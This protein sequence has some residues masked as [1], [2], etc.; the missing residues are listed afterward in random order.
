[1]PHIDDDF[2]DL[3][4]ELARQIKQEID[5]MKE[6]T[7]STIV[8]IEEE[9]KRKIA[10]DISSLE[11]RIIQN[12]EFELNKKI[13][14]RINEINQN[15]LLA[16]T[17]YIEKFISELKAKIASLVSKYPE[18][19]FRFLSKKLVEYGKIFRDGGKIRLNKQDSELLKKYPSEFSL[20]KK[21][22]EIDTNHA[23]IVAGFQ[24]FSKDMKYTIDFSVDSMLEKQKNEI[25]KMFMKIFPVF[26]V[27]VPDSIDIYQ[28]NKNLAKEEG[29][30][31]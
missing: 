28:K 1:M 19:Y 12:A 14:D 11:N 15:I 24:I 31:K 2:R 6:R 22:F 13:S 5:K 29:K 17:M 30:E 16:K 3:S 7:I 25:S 26:E 9:T 10:R 21:L 23:D 18:K 20:D 27:N 4:Y 8:Y